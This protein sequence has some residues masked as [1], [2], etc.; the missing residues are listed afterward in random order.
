MKKSGQALALL[1]GAGLAAA[2]TVMLWGDGG[3]GRLDG[4]T[5]AIVAAP[6]AQA[7]LEVPPAPAAAALP[8]V[9]A[10][11]ELPELPRQ[12]DFG[13]Q[14][15]A[16]EVRRVADWALSSGDT[17]RRPFVIVDKRRARLY[18]FE[19]GG[20]LRGAS[21]VLLGSARG[22]DTVP[23]IGDRP[24]EQVRPH[25]RTTPAGRFQGEIGRNLRGED[26]LWVD[27]DAAVSMHR[28][29]TTDPAER[30]LQRLASPGVRDNRISYG[31]INVPTAFFE[32]VLMP[33][34][35][36]GAAPVVYVLPEVRPLR[37][38]F[39]KLPPASAPALAQVAHGGGARHQP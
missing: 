25:E 23:G 33:V 36:A 34:S 16:A 37:E 35:R 21:P 10:L 18:V 24:L 5:P 26:V 14:A 9:P 29:L 1:A 12:A 22:D 19:S 39:L 11:P 4:G 38:V 7:P 20:Q 27:Y 6:E 8:E 28:V 13:T 3:S 30:R 15:A 17:E 31:C 2:A 32:Q